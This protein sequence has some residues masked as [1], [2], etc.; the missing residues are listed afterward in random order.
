MRI[1]KRLIAIFPLLLLAG[2]V[3]RG[4]E[5]LD[6]PQSVEVPVAPG[7]L[8]LE[9]MLSRA[10]S[11]HAAFRFQE[12]IGLYMSI[13]GADL[14]ARSREELDR[15]VAASQNGLNMTDFCATPHVVARQRFSRKDF[16]LFYPLG[17][18]AWHPS[19]NP[20][21]S[22][23]E[24]PLYC[25]KDARTVYFSA[26][27]KAGTRSLFVTEDRD[28]LWSAP[29]LLSE[30]ITSTGSEIYPMLSPDGKTLYF[31]S[32][33]LFG[34]GGYDLYSCTWDPETQ[35][36]GSPVNLGFP[37]SSPGDDFLLMDTPDGKYTLF[38]SNRDCS[39][40]SVYV[41]VVEYEKLRA[42]KAVRSHEELRQIA[43]LRPVNNPSRIDN[44]SAVS[45]GVSDNANTRLYMRK[46]QE[47]RALRDSLDR[48][49]KAIDGLRQ[50][51][52]RAHEDE[53]AALTASIREKEQAMTP[54]RK[55]LEETD[56]EIRLVE[57]T[58][59]QSG[60]V[61]SGGTEDREVVG[62]ASSYTFAKN[63]IGQRLKMKVEKPASRAY[64]RV[65]PV[66]R[67]ALDNTLPAGLVFQLEL[68]S[69]P[70]HA[71]VEDL[72]GLSPVYERLTSNLRYTYSVGLYPSYTAALADLNVV[73]L[74]GFPEARI[75][76]FRD[77]RPVSVSQAL[78]AE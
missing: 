36:W 29:R 3:L 27:D 35:G 13:S 59:L 4:Q 42:R 73:R 57:Q 60:V 15:K 41:Y 48:Y 20:L 25:P 68:F 55:L 58:F 2:T 56:L 76:A 67:F 18:R 37:F 77:G 24:Y 39:K 28:T 7:R 33:G 63:A 45:G 46:N 49:Q 44:A 8:S 34:M 70:R 43:S 10:D 50:Q 12:A 40:D 19:P 1:I 5:I 64:F 72:N 22:L 26:P 47:A 17:Q 6:R 51:I 16:F 53:T 21:D 23:A 75:V 38:A 14:N 61:Q 9:Q 65:A 52:T 74:L 31:A 78:R 32:D 62:S 11:L 54:V 71:S 66:G 69:T 30:S